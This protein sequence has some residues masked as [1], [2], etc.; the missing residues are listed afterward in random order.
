MRELFLLF[1]LL[2]PPSSHPIIVQQD[3]QVIDCQAEG[4][5]LL[6]GNGGD[7]GIVVQNRTG[8]IIQNCTVKGFD[9]GLLVADSSNVVVRNS[10]FS[11]NY[12]DDNSILDLGAW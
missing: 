2:I 9:L 5:P 12:I 4:R 8:V 6:V 1:A 10:N 11:G 3:N 7:T